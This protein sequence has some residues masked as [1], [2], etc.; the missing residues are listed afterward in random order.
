MYTV[1][2]LDWV[3]AEFAKGNH[4]PTMASPNAYGLLGF[5]LAKPKVQN[6][7]LLEIRLW[8]AGMQA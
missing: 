6:K 5:A 1:E 8:P 4:P 7:A 2:G 3:V